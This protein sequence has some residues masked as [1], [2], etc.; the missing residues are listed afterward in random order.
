MALPNTDHLF[1]LRHDKE[2]FE[3]ER[4]RLIDEHIQSLPESHQ[5]AARAMQDRIDAARQV[6]AD[7]EFLQWMVRETA[8]LSANL[9]DQFA[10]IGHVA[11]CMQKRLTDG[12]VG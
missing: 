9:S 4:T 2:R 6:M 11:D 12:S 7:D 5:L 10:Y 8:E 3:A 1:W